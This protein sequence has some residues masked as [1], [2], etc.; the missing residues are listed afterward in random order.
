MNGEWQEGQGTTT[1]EDQG[2]GGSATQPPLPSPQAQIRDDATG[3]KCEAGGLTNGEQEEGEE[4]S[5]VTSGHTEEV[6]EISSVSSSEAD[7]QT[8]GPT[9]QLLFMWADDQTTRTVVD[10]TS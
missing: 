7:E 2:A 8:T 10:V 4:A 6:M 3:T 9:I 5:S 1:S